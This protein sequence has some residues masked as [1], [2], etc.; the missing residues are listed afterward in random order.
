M[1]ASGCVAGRS[2]RGGR[3]AQYFQDRT[4]A[5]ARQSGLRDSS[6]SFRVEPQIYD[7]AVGAVRRQGPDHR[8]RGRALL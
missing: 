2:N 8:E 3:R 1:T 6:V 7:G 4:D 5:G